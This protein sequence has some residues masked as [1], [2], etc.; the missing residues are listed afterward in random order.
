MISIR[1]IS[2]KYNVDQAWIEELID[3]DLIQIDRQS[4][5]IQIHRDE[6]NLFEKMINLH[7]ELGLN[8]PGIAVALDLL[9]KIEALQQKINQ[10]QQRIQRLS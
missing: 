3:F 7:Q 5:D 10:Q 6:L 1:I 2:T 9:S 4:N 8:T